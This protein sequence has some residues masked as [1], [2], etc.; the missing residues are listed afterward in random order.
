[1]E[2][3]TSKIKLLV[4]PL[5]V[6]V[7]TLIIF[8]LI[9]FLILFTISKNYHGNRSPHKKKTPSTETIDDSSDEANDSLYGKYYYI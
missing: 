8:L 6:A 4:K 1:M 5:L 3:N 7:I 2:N 9:G